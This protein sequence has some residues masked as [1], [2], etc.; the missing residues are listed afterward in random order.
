[1]AIARTYRAWA[2]AR[3]HAVSE[4]DGLR[5]RGAIA[6]RD[7]LVDPGIDGR[8]PGWVIVTVQVALPAAESVLVTRASRASNE[9]TSAIRALFDDEAIG[10]DL[11]AISVASRHVRLR[12]APGAP[13]DAVEAAV[14]AVAHALRTLYASP[15]SES[16]A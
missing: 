9:V 3:G 6:G 12:L 13:P 10:P 1:M 5:I 11:R 8:A 16:A 2:R 14:G 4:A 7:A 15:S